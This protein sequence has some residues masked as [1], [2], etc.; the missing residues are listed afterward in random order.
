M[1]Q[2]LFKATANAAAGS[3]LLAPRPIALAVLAFGIYG[4]ASIL[5][6]LLL[7]HV[8]LSRV[9][10]YLGLSFIIVPIAAYFLLGEALM[11]RHMLGSALIAFGVVVAVSA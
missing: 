10:P 11:P 2:I 5:W 9:Y 7:Q 6:I 8:P 1:G 3:T 4:G